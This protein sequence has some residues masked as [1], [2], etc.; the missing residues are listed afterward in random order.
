MYFSQDLDPDYTPFFWRGSLASV[1]SKY[2]ILDF[3]DLKNLTT[4]ITHSEND[5]TR[6]DIQDDQASINIVNEVN[7][8]VPPTEV[9]STQGEPL[10][11]PRTT[12]YRV[13]EEPS[14][15]L[16]DVQKQDQFLTL[17]TNTSS[18]S[19]I[20][21][22]IDAGSISDI[23]TTL[24]DDTIRA[25]VLDTKMIIENFTSAVDIP[26]EDIRLK[27]TP[28]HQQHVMTASS[29]YITNAPPQ[30]DPA[31]S[32]QRV[33]P[34]KGCASNDSIGELKTDSTADQTD[35]DRN[36][37]RTDYV[38]DSSTCSSGY[39][40]ESVMSGLLSNYDTQQSCS[41]N[42]LEQDDQLDNKGSLQYVASS[43]CA[44]ESATGDSECVFKCRSYSKTERSS[45]H[46][47]HPA[48]TH[49]EIDSGCNY[50]PNSPSTSSSSEN[51]EFSSQTSLKLTDIEV[52]LDSVKFT[53]NAH[54]QFDYVNAIEENLFKDVC[55]DIAP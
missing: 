15:M 28:C 47:E 6:R 3:S 45:Q 22:N 11:Q 14:A 27:T 31:E 1:H 53:V 51:T 2:E 40:T 9:S 50:V 5:E 46:S 29:G 37:D 4:D 48:S 32:Q 12:D 23:L 38:A 17:T 44:S 8:L 41:S 52:D 26:T 24:E 35:K 16:N 55:F 54:Q 20:A 42:T 7:A 25:G 30:H 33:Y 10:Q 49:V 36:G 34:E 19:S 21:I 13:L 18:T 39:I 43:R